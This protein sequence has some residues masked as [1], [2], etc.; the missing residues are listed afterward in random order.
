MLDS[1]TL[2]LSV[3][4][5][6]FNGVAST[7][8]YSQDPTAS[9]GKTIQIHRKG[10]TPYLIPNSTKWIQTANDPNACRTWQF[11]FKGERSC[12]GN[13]GSP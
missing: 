6:G 3:G 10:Q 13:S 4:D 7:Q 12:K 2:L 1:D 8:K 11:G 5:F 9:Y